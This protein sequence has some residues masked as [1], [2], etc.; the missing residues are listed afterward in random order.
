MIYLKEQEKR[1]P[2]KLPKPRSKFTDTKKISMNY[3]EEYHRGIREFDTRDYYTPKQ[4][5]APT[6]LD[7]IRLSMSA[8]K[9]LY[10]FDREFK[11][12]LY[13]KDPSKLNNSF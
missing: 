9:A 13:N 2:V 5:F 11:R 1:Q 10:E 4:K 6:Y 8:R 7:N 3:Y 12:T